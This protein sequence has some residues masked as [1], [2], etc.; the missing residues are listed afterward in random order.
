MIVM[1][2]SLNALTCTRSKIL[3]VQFVKELVNEAGVVVGHPEDR[4]HR[5]SIAPGVDAPEW[6]AMVDAHIQTM[7]FEELAKSDLR[8]ILEMA[9][10]KHTPEVV[11]AYEAAVEAA[12][13]AH[14]ALAAPE[15]PAAKKAKPTRKKSAKK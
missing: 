15:A 4:M 10:L 14:V 6:M 1:K 7:G 2:M 9:A 12:N 8:E 13:A 3:E 5:T 11:A